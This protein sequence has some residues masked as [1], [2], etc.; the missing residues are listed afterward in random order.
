[1]TDGDVPEW[2][3]TRLA[4]ELIFPPELHVPL[5][6]A[7]ADFISFFYRGGRSDD[8]GSNENDGDIFLESRLP[9]RFDSDFQLIYAAFL[10]LYGIDLITVPYLHW[11]KFRALFLGLHDCKFCDVIGYRM[12][13]TSEM[14]EKMRQSY[15]KLQTAYALPVSVT[16]RRRIETAR[17]FLEN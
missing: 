1:M 15:E 17:S 3:R 2:E 14:S 16:E 9:Y 12:A 13:D 5:T 4:A 10:E 8:S 11:W 6:K 7:T